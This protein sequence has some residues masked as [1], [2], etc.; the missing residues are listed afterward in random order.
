MRTVTPSSGVPGTGRDQMVPPPSVTFSISQPFGLGLPV[1]TRAWFAWK[2]RY[3]FRISSP[4]GVL[5]RED[6]AYAGV[7]SSAEPGSEA[8]AAAPDSAPE[9]MR[10]CLRDGSNTLI[11]RPLVTVGL[12]DRS[13]SRATTDIAP[14]AM[15]RMKAMAR[16]GLTYPGTAAS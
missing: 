4:V 3:A 10:S 16:A 9:R 12:V 15:A 2:R 1:S 13:W 8:R 14:V 11:H 7:A 6:A 5:E